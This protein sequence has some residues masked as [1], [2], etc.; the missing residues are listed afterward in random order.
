A[1]VERLYRVDEKVVL[2]ERSLHEL[3]FLVVDFDRSVAHSIYVTDFSQQLSIFM[4]FHKGSRPDTI[5]KSTFYFDIAIFEKAFVL[6]V[7]GLIISEDK[8]VFLYFLAS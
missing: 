6:A 2:I 1:I 8:I 7:D 5:F 3:T 4:I